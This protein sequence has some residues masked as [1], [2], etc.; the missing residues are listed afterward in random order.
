[1]KTMRC[2]FLAISLLTLTSCSLSKPRVPIEVQIVEGFAADFRQNYIRKNVDTVVDDLLFKLEN[3][4]IDENNDRFDT[5][6]YKLKEDRDI[7]IKDVKEIKDVVSIYKS[8][9][10]SV[11]S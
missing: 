6:V 9:D 1:M 5:A 3:K 7:K 8:Y 10:D 4:W 2:F 11:E